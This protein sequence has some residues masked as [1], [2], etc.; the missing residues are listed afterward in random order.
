MCSVILPSAKIKATL[1]NVYIKNENK[2]KKL[3]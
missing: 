2:R 1:G 3:E